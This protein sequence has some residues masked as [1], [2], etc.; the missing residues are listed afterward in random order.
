MDKVAHSLNAKV[1]L[2]GLL[3][4]PVVL[5]GIPPE[6]IYNGRSV[7]LIHTLF[8]WECPE[9]GITRALFSL[10]HLD[11]GRAWEYHPLVFIIGPLLLYL[12]LKEV[13]KTTG[14]L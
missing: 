4:M 11:V 12:Y 13:R 6:Y 2:T 7:C 1:R 14:A 3:L 5:Y 10:L 8:N 9:C